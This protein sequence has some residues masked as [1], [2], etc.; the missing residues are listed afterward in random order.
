MSNDN[1]QTHSQAFV[2]A[3]IL[4]EQL[5]KVQDAQELSDPKRVLS[6]EV[7]HLCGLVDCLNNTK[8]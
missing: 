8:T 1:I 3:K 4:A 5:F 7:K 2:K 6:T